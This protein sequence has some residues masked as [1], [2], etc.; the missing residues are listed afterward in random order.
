MEEYLTVDELSQKTKHA[1]QSVYNSTHKG[2]RQVKNIKFS[3][4]EFFLLIF[5]FRMNT[6]SYVFCCPP[7]SSPILLYFLFLAGNPCK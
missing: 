3:I 1:R 2:R 6:I 7:L 5:N 4:I